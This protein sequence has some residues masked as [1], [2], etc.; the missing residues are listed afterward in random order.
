M[1][2]L[3]V[4]SGILL[5]LQYST[6]AE[7][8]ESPQGAYP[9]LNDE[10]FPESLQPRGSRN[11]TPA[12]PS[13][14]PYG[15]ENFIVEMNKEEFAKEAVNQHKGGP[16]YRPSWLRATSEGPKRRETE[17]P[18]TDMIRESGTRVTDAVAMNRYN[19]MYFQQGRSALN[20][21]TSQQ[22][23]LPFEQVRE[24]YSRRG[25]FDGIDPVLGRNPLPRYNRY[26]LGEER[27]TSMG[28]DG[29]VRGFAF[30]EAG[31]SETVRREGWEVM[32]SRAVAAENPPQAIRS[33]GLR[34]GGARGMPISMLG[35]PL[36]EE[37]NDHDGIEYL[38]P[39]AGR[40]ANVRSMAARYLDT[41][42]AFQAEDVDTS[43]QLRGLANTSYVPQGTQRQGV[44]RTGGLR[45]VPDADRSKAYTSGSGVA[46]HT[47]VPH[48]RVG[49]TPE[50]T[51]LGPT[52]HG[53]DTLAV[54]APATRIETQ[55]GWE[56]TYDIGQ[57]TAQIQ[58][59]RVPEQDVR[60]ARPTAQPITQIDRLSR[61]DQEAV[62]ADTQVW[63]RPE[64]H[65][66]I[67]QLTSKPDRSDTM[68]AVGSD[69]AL[70]IGEPISLSKQLQRRTLPAAVPKPTSQPDR[71]VLFSD[72]ERNDYKTD[73]KS[74]D[75]HRPDVGPM[76]VRAAHGANAAAL[77]SIQHPRQEQLTTIKTF[78]S[79]S[80]VNSRLRAQT[81][82]APRQGSET[83]TVQRA[84]SFPTDSGF[85]QAQTTTAVPRMQPIS[86][87]VASAGTGGAK[88]QTWV[89]PGNSKAQTVESTSLIHSQKRD[90][91]SGGSRYARNAG[92]AEVFGRPTAAASLDPIQR[93]QETQESSDQVRMDNDKIVDLAGKLRQPLRAPKSSNP[94]Y[95]QVA[96]NTARQAGEFRR[97]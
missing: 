8:E 74:L 35:A 31:R 81:A 12:G 72:E 20:P 44:V 91:T 64:P 95:A 41:R 82:D 46:A 52:R 47:A 65:Q 22:G 28:D 51:V 58:R 70:T 77:V 96:I 4:V 73:P 67:H 34:S 17:I 90:Q 48:G 29:R 71:R 40:M 84:G 94:D 93:F 50:N 30:G 43:P 75:M 25:G 26:D 62:A 13:H 5:G 55:R 10:R 1:E 59:I 2:A 97:R 32:P 78:E 3:L 27:T 76:T 18:D 36:A 87:A 53:V 16:V 56:Y 60:V 54:G 85:A 88:K 33:A 83:N 11:H 38:D 14:P 15:N 92:K 37:S 19:D 24:R 79:G 23:A 86:S 6:T 68:Q 21:R 63:R 61:G 80:L 45:H 7:N 42:G 39:R 66:V 57:L 89:F 9:N 69:K 49:R